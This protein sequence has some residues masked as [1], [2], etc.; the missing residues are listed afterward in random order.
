RVVL[1]AANESDLD[2]LPQEVLQAVQFD[3]VKT[4]DEVMTVALTRLPIRGSMEA[5]N[6]VLSAPQG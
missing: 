2:T 5:R 3:L 4:M 6:V 1:P